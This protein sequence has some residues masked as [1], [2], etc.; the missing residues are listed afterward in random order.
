MDISVIKFIR[1]LLEALFIGFCIVIPI[2]SFIKTNLKTLHLKE[3]FILQAI[4]AVRIAGIL[5]A[6]TYLHEVNLVYFQKASAA[7]AIAPAK[8]VPSAYLSYMFYPPLA[9]LLLTQLLWI[10]KAYTNKAALLISCLILLIAPQWFYIMGLLR[11]S[12]MDYYQP[13]WLLLLG[14]MLRNTF[15][16]L[17]I[18]FSI[19]F[20]LMLL[21]GKLK[22]REVS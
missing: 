12:E 16:G 20:I 21:S 18:L 8:L 3:L 15:Q 4:K 6:L 22:L 5:Y 2:L 11:I 7:D 14:N 10:K 13:D 9:Y 19:T 1:A 17:F